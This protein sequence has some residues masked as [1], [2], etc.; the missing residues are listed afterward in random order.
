M[1]KLLTKENL[2]KIKIIHIYGDTGTG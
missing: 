1:K 2:E